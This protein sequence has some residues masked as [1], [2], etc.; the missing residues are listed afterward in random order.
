[1][2]MFRVA[3]FAGSRHHQLSVMHTA[4]AQ[5]VVSQLLQVATV[6]LHDDHF[7]TVVMVQMDMGRGEHL[8]VRVVLNLDEFVGEIGAVMI[9]DHR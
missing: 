7:Q 6:T 2:A 8:V 5:N 4:Q 3:D 9:V 1:M